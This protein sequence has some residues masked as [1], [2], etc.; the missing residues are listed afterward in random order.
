MKNFKNDA[1]MARIG[2]IP[3]TLDQAGISLCPCFRRDYIKLVDC[4]LIHKQHIPLFIDFW[5]DG[6]VNATD[7]MM[8]DTDVI[9]SELKFSWRVV[10]VMDVILRL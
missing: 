6:M 3:G 5:N 4:L 1:C 2:K 10:P 8:P 7:E 9:I